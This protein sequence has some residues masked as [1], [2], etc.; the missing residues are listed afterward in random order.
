MKK[1]IENNFNLEFNKDDDNC[2]VFAGCVTNLRIY[3]F[4]N[5]KNE[6]NKLK[7]LTFFQC[8]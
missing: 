6:N 2:C 5:Q 1:K 4:K 3:N 8:K 7:F